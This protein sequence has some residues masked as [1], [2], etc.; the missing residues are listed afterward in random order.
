MR[1]ARPARPGRRCHRRSAHGPQITSDLEGRIAFGQIGGGVR[2][3]SIR[4]R[5]PRLRRNQRAD[6][7][8]QGG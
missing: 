8:W 3:Q 2:Q 6:G 7:R 1:P 4:A 5:L